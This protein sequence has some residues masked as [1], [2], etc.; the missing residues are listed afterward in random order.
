M[1]LWFREG[2]VVG[3]G[4]WLISALHYPRLN[5]NDSKQ[6]EAGQVSPSA[7]GLASWLA[8]ASFNMA[9]S[10][11]SGILPGGSELLEQIFPDNWAEAVRLFMTQPWKFQSIISA[12][13]FG[14][15]MLPKHS[16]HSNSL[17]YC[18]FDQLNGAHLRRHFFPL[19]PDVLILI[20][21]LHIHWLMLDTYAI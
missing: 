19:L 18:C 3:S 8:W 9:A 6:K 1:N 14:S 15:C 21:L 13:F 12:I 4:E 7:Q 16:Q 17:C 5:Q 11:W 20:I 10:G 2:L